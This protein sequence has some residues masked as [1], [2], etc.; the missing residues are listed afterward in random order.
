MTR[1]NAQ[2]TKPLKPGPT[3]KSTPVVAPSDSEPRAISVEAAARQLGISR[4]AA[5]NYANDGSLPVIR[6]GSRL[7]VPKAALDKL[8]AT[9]T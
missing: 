5:Y 2:S 6:L 1:K 9:G 8:L 4:A 3:H 7:L